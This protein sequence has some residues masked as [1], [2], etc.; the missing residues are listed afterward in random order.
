MIGIKMAR[1]G[2]IQSLCFLAGILAVAGAAPTL[3][4]NS[5]PDT[6]KA[7]VQVTVGQTAYLESLN[8]VN[9]TDEMRKTDVENMTE[10]VLNAINTTI[11]SVEVTKLEVYNDTT[12]SVEMTI[13]VA[14]N[15]ADPWTDRQ[16]HVQEVLDSV[17]TQKPDFLFSLDEAII[18]ETQPATDNTTT[19]A[20]DGSGTTTP[21]GG[22]SGATN[23]GTTATGSNADTS[24][25]SA[26]SA[27][28]TP[29]GTN[30]VSASDTTPA[31][32][33]TTTTRTTT[34]TA[35]ST[36]STNEVSASDT[37]PAG[38]TT[39][40]TRT[41]TTTAESTGSTNEVSASDTTPAGGMSHTPPF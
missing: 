23:G 17:K 39:T 41:T 7:Y 25:P 18:S 22:G 16:A 20:G 40:T 19:P 13:T 30:E 29:T 1:N 9:P 27:T 5:Q 24:N 11:I 26:D 36:G 12:L 35:E 15:A 4:T 3:N 33:T 2:V 6:C 28:A 8:G 31:G 14:C 32:D 38:D 37:T 34:T 21:A 10:V